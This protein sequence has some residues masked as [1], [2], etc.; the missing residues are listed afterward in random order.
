MVFSLQYFV[1]DPASHRQLMKK[2]RV[3]K[4]TH[5]AMFS[6]FVSLLFPAC[7]SISLPLPRWSVPLRRLMVES[8]I[9]I[10]ETGMMRAFCFS[11]CPVSEV[12]LSKRKL[13][14]STLWTFLWNSRIYNNLSVVD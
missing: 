11:S 12:R 5:P 14:G 3:Y 4:T 1:N 13:E 10:L 6:Q 7:F 2:P 8:E 9:E